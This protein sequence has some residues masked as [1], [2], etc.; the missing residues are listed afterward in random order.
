MTFDLIGILRDVLVLS[1]LLVLR[2][3]VP[4]LVTMIGGAWLRKVLEPKEERPRTVT[5]PVTHQAQKS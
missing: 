5:P 2:V 3:G 4:V 1:Y